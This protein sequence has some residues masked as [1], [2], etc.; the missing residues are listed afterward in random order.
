MG[1]GLIAMHPGTDLESKRENLVVSIIS[2][3]ASNGPELIEDFYR[4]LLWACRLRASEIQRMLLPWRLISPPTALAL[5][6]VRRLSSCFTIKHIHKALSLFPQR[7]MRMFFFL[8]FVSIL[9]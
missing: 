3:S 7:S 5:S 2:I 9:I 4:R 1:Q 6:L 8:I